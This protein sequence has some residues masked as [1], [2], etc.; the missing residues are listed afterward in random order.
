MAMAERK[1]LPGV[2]E[3]GDRP[4]RVAVVV[5]ATVDPLAAGQG[6]AGLVVAGQQLSFAAFEAAGVAVDQARVD[7]AE[8]LVVD[9]EAL[10]GVVAHVVLDDVGPLDQAVED[11]EALGAP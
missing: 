11:G 5:E 1:P 10:G 3:R 4:D 2:A 8:R 7:G 6:R 9:A